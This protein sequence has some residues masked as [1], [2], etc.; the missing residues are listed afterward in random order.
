MAK[1]NHNKTWVAG[2]MLEMWSRERRGEKR[3][4]EKRRGDGRIEEYVERRVG[5]L[6]ER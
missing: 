1:M 5:T 4:E 3:M 2:T 6:E